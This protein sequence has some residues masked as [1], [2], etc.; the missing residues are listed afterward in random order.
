MQ[1]GVMSYFLKK[2]DTLTANL[3]SHAKAS[4]GKNRAGGTSQ[5]LTVG[6][7]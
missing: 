4:K 5:V 1:S 2:Q 7:Y 3:W 6:Y